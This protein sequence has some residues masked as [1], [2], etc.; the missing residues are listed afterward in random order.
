WKAVVA[1][2]DQVMAAHAA[3]IGAGFKGQVERHDWD[4]VVVYEITPETVAAGNADRAIFYVH[5]GA[6]LFGGGEIA[7]TMAL[8]HAQ[9]GACK[10]F[11]ADYRM[12]PDHPF[13]AALDDV[14]AA[15]DRVLERYPA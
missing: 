14:S 1:A 5:G 2:G 10:V 3:K 12:P 11:S 8:E 9:I 4:G 15:Y 6:Y 7:A 13:P